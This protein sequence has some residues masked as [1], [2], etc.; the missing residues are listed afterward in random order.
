MEQRLITLKN[1]QIK[2][3]YEYFGNL[4]SKDGKNAEFSYMIYK[5]AEILSPMYAE[6]V[7][8]IY[9][10]NADS[11][12][13]KFL[14]AGREL[15][16]KYADRDEQGNVITDTN[17][18]P[19]VNEQIAEFNTENTALLEEYKAVISARE[20]RIKESVEYLETSYE[21]NLFVVHLENMPN[22][23]QPAIVGI[24]GI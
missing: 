6:I 8:K 2:A 1:G 10:E 5:N 22:D 9:N 12:F 24:F 16:S 15:I 13:Q 18:N 21:L 20:Q 14:Q 4:L 7:N 23:T 19:L 17:G 11:E 3:I